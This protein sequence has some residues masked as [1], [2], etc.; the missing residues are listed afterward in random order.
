[1]AASTKA[2]V[3]PK[4]ARTLVE[5]ILELFAE[6]GKTNAQADAAKLGRFFSPNLQVVSNENNVVSNLNQF[7]ER[8]RT[9]KSNYPTITYSK[10][11]VEP[12]VSANRVAI[13]YNAE[14]TDKSGKK[15]RLQILA[16]L[17]L[18]NDKVTSWH[19][20]IHEKGTGSVDP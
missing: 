10:L 8:I 12:V 14:P 1:M 7:Q 18:E 2:P 6:F 16:I 9:W 4:Q 11:L 13:R 20:V 19:E 5:G 3:D 15:H 17:T